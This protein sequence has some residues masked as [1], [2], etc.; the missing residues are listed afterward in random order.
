MPPLPAQMEL[1]TAFT[2]DFTAAR[3]LLTPGRE[4]EEARTLFLP[5]SEV[6]QPNQQVRDALRQLLIRAKLRHEPTYIFINNRIEGFAPGTMLA[7]T[8]GL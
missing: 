3:A 6:R 8:D 7:I 2:A 4:Y 5:F 1:E